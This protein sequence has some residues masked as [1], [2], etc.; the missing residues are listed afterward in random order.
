[1]T[2]V[3]F[4]LRTD[5]PLVHNQ[6]A[7]LNHVYF[8][9]CFS[10]GSLLT[11]TGNGRTETKHRRWMRVAKHVP[12]SWNLQ[13][14]KN[15][16]TLLTHSEAPNSASAQEVGAL[17]LQG[18]K[19]KPCHTSR[20]HIKTGRFVL[21]WGFTGLVLCGPPEQSLIHIGQYSTA[22]KNPEAGGCPERGRHLEHLPYGVTTQIFILWFTRQTNTP[23]ENMYYWNSIPCRLVIA[24]NLSS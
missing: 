23:L 13:R 7:V 6:G 5:L 12:I 4:N 16:A 21:Q 11:D 9:S 8:S 20:W 19:F 17:W 3:P 18:L 22:H 10:A 15:I 1:M 2:H 24:W 14:G